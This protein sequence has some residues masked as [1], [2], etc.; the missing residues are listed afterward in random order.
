[1][2]FTI[3]WL[4]DHLDTNAKNQE[5][6]ETLTNLGLEVEESTDQS[7]AL[8][9]FVVAEV[10]DVKKHPDADKLQICGVNT[11]NKTIEVVCGASNVRKGMKSVFA[12]LGT[13]IPSTGDK[14]T[15]VKIRGIYSHGML[16]SARDLG[17]S[18]DHEGIIKLPDDSKIGESCSKFLG[19]NDFLISIDV[20]PNRSDCL[21][22]RGIA[23]DLAA[24]GLGKL[25]P[26]VGKKVNGHFKSS[27][28][29]IL[30]F[31]KTKSSLCPVF[32][33]R[34]IR[35]IKNADSPR[36]LSER[37]YSV[38]LKP[39]SALVDIT[40][41]FTLNLG[42]PLHVFDAKKINGDLR[43]NLSQ[44]GEKLAALDGKVYSLKDDMVVIR[45]KNKVL[46]LGG[47]IGG[48]ESGCNHE[49]TDTFLECAHFDPKS[50][51][52]TG[53]KLMI[54]S[55]S[56]FRFERGVDPTSVLPGIE[57]ATKMI[58]DICGGEPSEIVIAGKKDFTKKIINFDLR[59]VLK[60][61]GLKISAQKIKTSLESLGF[62][63]KGKGNSFSVNVPSWRNDIDVPADLVEEVL[64]IYGYD[65]IPD[66]PFTKV[67]TSVALGSSK[68]QKIKDT[69]KRSFATRGFYE[70]ITWSFMDGKYA[71]LFG[72]DN[73]DLRLVNPISADL[74][75]MRPSILPNLLTAAKKNLDRGSGSF[76]LF[77]I[78]PSYSSIHSDGQRLCA[79]GIRVGS[80]DR[81]WRRP[82]KKVD[83][84][85]V[86]ADVLS[87][88]Q[89][90]QISQENLE[91]SNTAAK[92]YHPARAA[93]FSQKDALPLVSFGE[94]HPEVLSSFN[95]KV[96]VVG[97]ELYIDSLATLSGKKMMD[98]SGLTLSSLQSVERDFAF[99]VDQKITSQEIVAVSYT[100]LTLPTILLV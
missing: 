75:M 30:D 86:K 84:Y 85:D 66:E 67:S 40:N 39:V 93:S 59:E 99:V 44:S 10:Q 20:T 68:Q 95:I 100:H 27:I 18:E 69:V 36:W 74:D 58:I 78:G 61:T 76:A 14:I 88:L 32:A 92:W 70:V 41:Y 51:S 94:L 17:L 22:V 38:G 11:G 71:S 83:F 82:S 12:D 28:N 7:K 15:K 49:T 97:F 29:I 60:L 34:Y 5:I 96:P 46:S 72:G 79:A 37:L 26:L 80:T 16:C 21:S 45:D 47:V 24:A 63:L 13:I 48:E 8:Q 56:R 42:R 33:G 65:N 35:N 98:D 64:R 62:S 53:R 50:I 23:R 73:Q 19:L 89:I 9:P 43:V 2:K 6:L 55:D 57:S 77:E 81:H 3:S 31:P 90:S 52:S 25:K 87:F 91:I 54:D 1:M 4:K